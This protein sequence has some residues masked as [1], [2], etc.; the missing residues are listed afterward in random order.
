MP[1]MLQFFRDNIFIIDFKNIITELTKNPF[2]QTEF[3]FFFFRILKIDFGLQI[4]EF[5]FAF[6]WLQ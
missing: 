5:F 3:F 4:L 6:K 2:A 1:I